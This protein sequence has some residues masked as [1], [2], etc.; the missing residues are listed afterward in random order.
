MDEGQQQEQRWT[1]SERQR[2]GGSGQF[3]LPGGAN[4]EGR[5]RNTGHKKEGSTGVCKLQQAQQDLE[6][7]RHQQEDKDNALQDASAF[8][9]F[10]RL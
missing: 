10:L 8:S 4:D 6:R 3:H 1:E 7:E 9:A 2:G 5:R